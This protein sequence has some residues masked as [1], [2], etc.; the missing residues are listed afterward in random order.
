MDE[1]LKNWLNAALHDLDAQDVTVSVVDGKQQNSYGINLDS[2]QFV[3]GVFYWP[4]GTYEAQFNDCDSGEVIL[5][6]TVCFDEP[7]LLE[8]YLDQLIFERLARRLD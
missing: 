1:A 8:K 2:K 4:K 3:G 5:L 6:E 7:K